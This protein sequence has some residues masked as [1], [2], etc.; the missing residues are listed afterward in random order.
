MKIFSIIIINLIHS[1]L[2][3][4]VE[5]SVTNSA[6]RVAKNLNFSLSQQ[7]RIDYSI[8]EPVTYTQL[9]NGKR[10]NNGFIQPSTLIPIS[11]GGSNNNASSALV[12]NVFPNPNDGSFTIAVNSTP[13]E[14][15]NL[16]LIDARGRL[17]SIFRMEQDTFRITKLELPIGIYYL[18]FYDSKG[19]FLLQK[20]ISIL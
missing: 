11:S 12:A 15:Y 18:N 16:Q 19:S 20:N 2:F 5:R 9:A 3:A 17:V 10:I 7:K 6:G 14:Y 13:L 1:L 4:Q 8:G